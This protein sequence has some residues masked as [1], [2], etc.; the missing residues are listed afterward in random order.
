M[1]KIQQLCAVVANKKAGPHF[2]RL[3]LDAPGLAGKARPGQ[4]IHVRVDNGS[5]RPFFRRPFSVSRAQKHVEILYEVLGTGTALLSARKKGDRLDV[6]GPLGN[7]FRMPDKGIKQVA[8]IAGGMGLAP[9]LFL[10]DFL[11]KKKVEVLL[12]YGARTAQHIFPLKEFKQNGCRVFVATD[13]G[14]AGRKGRVSVLYP[15]INPDPGATLIYACGPKPMLAGLQ[16]FAQKHGLKGQASCE[17]VMACGLGA[18]L[19]CAIKTTR[20]Y[21][22]VCNDGPVFDLDELV[23]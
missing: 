21:K 4:F 7:G 11:K 22:T 10:S 20:G 19:G 6:L 16:R 1:K 2:Y 17:E 8:L 15:E 5:L 13:D 9:F 18:C 14:S 12:L 3:S 23:F